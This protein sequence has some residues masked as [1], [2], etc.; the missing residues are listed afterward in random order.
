MVLAKVLPKGQITIPK[1][2]RERL[3]IKEGDVI[4]LEEVEDGVLLRKGRTLFDVAG[5]IE[6]E[7]DVS[8]K[9]L[10]EEAREGEG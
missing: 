1:R 3:G 7:G 6:I 2:I 8:L 5:S 9:A 10:I 4:S